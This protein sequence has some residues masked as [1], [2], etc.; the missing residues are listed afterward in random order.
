MHTSSNDYVD[1]L[2]SIWERLVQRHCDMQKAG[3]EEP[4]RRVCEVGV[5]RGLPVWLM[6]A[7]NYFYRVCSQSRGFGFLVVE[8]GT[9][10]SPSW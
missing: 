6:M 2:N 10:T 5:E 8:C 3:D 7:F 1:F 4:K 9:C